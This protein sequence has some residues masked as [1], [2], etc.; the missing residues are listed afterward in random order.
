MVRGVLTPLQKTGSSHPYSRSLAWEDW[1]SGDAN[2][3]S[4]NLR[5]KH[6]SIN[7]K[8]AR[9]RVST[10]KARCVSVPLITTRRGGSLLAAKR[11]QK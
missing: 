11:N 8:L 10:G 4:L 3:F 7:P 5:G 1:S 9:V 6:S 2:I